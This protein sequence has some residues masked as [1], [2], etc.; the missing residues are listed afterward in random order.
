MG[1]VGP[2]ATPTFHAGKIYSL[3]ATGILNCLDAATGDL[4]WS[5]DVKLDGEQATPMWGFC[6]S[7]LIV[8]G[9]VIIFAGGGKD[10]AVP[11][12]QSAEAKATALDPAPVVR[13]TL[14]AYDAES[15]ELSWRAQSGTHSYSSPMLAEFSGKQQVLFVSENAVESVDPQTGQRLWELESNSKEG[16][17]CIQPHL[18]G[19]NQFLA[20]FTADGG[21]IRAR[22]KH[23]DGTWSTEFEWV[24]R[25][26][27]PFFSDFVRYD[28]NLY[29]FDGSVFCCVDAETGKRHWKQGRQG[30]YGSGQMLLL[31]D[32]PVLFVITEAGE[33]VLVAA[34]P[35]KHEELGK[36]QAIEGKT[37]NHPTI[38]GNRLY[39]RNAEEMAC[40]DLT[41]SA[42]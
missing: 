21:V 15:G 38:V 1:G 18:L 32:Q 40:F 33:A 28:G 14:I 23:D 31:A 30:R 11:N 20:S 6:S 41:Q 35:H 17:P 12:D 8:D 27:K 7:P 5:K 16:N 25:D 9:R 29:G 4:T 19:D 22:V 13:K 34:N 24:S 39:V 10:G 3:G 36:F 42:E 37:W 2:R 26:I